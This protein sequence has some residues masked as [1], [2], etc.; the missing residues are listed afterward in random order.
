MEERSRPRNAYSLSSKLGSPAISDA[1]ID[2]R[3]A[4]A[5]LGTH[6]E[7]TVAPPI[8]VYHPV[9]L[10]HNTISDLKSVSLT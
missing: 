10:A 1:R 8:K 2:V 9:F 3:A 4:V 7:V 6:F 5:T